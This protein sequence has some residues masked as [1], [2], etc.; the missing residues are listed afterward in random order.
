MYLPLLRELQAETQKPDLEINFRLPKSKPRPHKTLGS[1]SKKEENLQKSTKK[2]EISFRKQTSAAN[3]WR[4]FTS[5]PSVFVRVLS[6]QKKPHLPATSPQVS[7]RILGTFFSLSVSL[8][9]SSL[10]GVG[11]HC[12]FIA[13]EKV[14]RRRRWW[15]CNNILK[16]R[17]LLKCAGHLPIQTK[18]NGKV[19]RV[20]TR[21]S[22]VPRVNLHLGPTR[23]FPFGCRKNFGFVFFGRKFGLMSRFKGFIH[24]DPKI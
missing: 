5:F 11:F 10:R 4:I 24:V 9:L 14:V 21:I 12:H 3:Q 7:P 8:S 13:E 16:N 19:V 17:L 1:K 22:N 20:I 23:E 18:W 6:E 2:D 15:I